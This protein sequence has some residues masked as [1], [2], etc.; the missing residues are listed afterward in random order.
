VTMVYGGL[1]NKKIVASLCSLEN[2][3]LGLTG[4]DSNLILAHKRPL[5]N[6]INF[7]WVGDIDS[8]NS[9]VI[10]GFLN[11]GILPVL[12]PLT[13][14]GNGHLLNTNADTIASSVAQAMTEYYDVKLI[15]CFEKYGV[16]KDVNDD[17]SFIQDLQKSEYELMAE[18][19]LI[20]A[21]MLPKLAN[22]FKSLEKGVLEVVIGHSQKVK[23][24]TQKNFNQCTRIRN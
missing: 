18:N 7:G 14:D 23:E 21:G 2:N 8:V 12:A 22:A 15:Y 6:G 5:K 24:L 9:E 19:G 16:L 1:I 10:D 11:S 13:S 17:N 20:H 3:A 4:A